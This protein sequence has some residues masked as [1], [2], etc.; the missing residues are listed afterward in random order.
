LNPSR[1][2]VAALFLA[3]LLAPLIHAR[4]NDNSSQA[5]R[6]NN[7][8]ILPGGASGG[9]ITVTTTEAELAATYGKTNVVAQ[10][11]DLGEGETE[12]GTAL[13]PHDPTREVD[14]LWKDPQVKRSHK[15]VQISGEKS[16]WKTV[17]GITLGASLKTLEQLN[18][19]PF[20]LAGFGWD[21]S[22]TVTSWNQ[23][24]IEGELVRPGRVILRLQ[25][26]NDPAHSKSERSVLGDRDFSS[27]HPAMQELNP[28][29][30][31]IIW[32]FP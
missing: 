9:T 11:I 15:Q 26:T 31:Q 18:R 21:Y 4:Q 17:H 23:G 7:W 29:V 6:S 30:Y 2:A 32:R 16:K 28:R 20:L 25:P 19:K 3:S 24:A 5:S 1:L 14:I 22:G 13:F 27:G 10:D 12:P 8:L